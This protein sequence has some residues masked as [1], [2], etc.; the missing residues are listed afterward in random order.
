MF[1]A[2]LLDFEEKPSRRVQAYTEKT[3]IKNGFGQNFR[4]YS[5]FFVT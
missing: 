1:T 2:K 4:G 5:M 3:E